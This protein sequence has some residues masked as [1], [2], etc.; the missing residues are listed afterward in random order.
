MQFLIGLLFRFA[1]IQ[2]KDIYLYEGVNDTYM[3][4]GNEAISVTDQYYGILKQAAK[5]NAALLSTV[6][7]LAKHFKVQRSKKEVLPI[8]KLKQ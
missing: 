5:G 3:A 6:S 7:E 8:E 1:L 2:S 4:A